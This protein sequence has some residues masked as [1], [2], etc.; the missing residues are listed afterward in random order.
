M[1]RKPRNCFETL[2][3]HWS[4]ASSKS[5]CVVC[6]RNFCSFCSLFCCIQCKSFWK[7]SFF[8]MC[9]DTSET[10]LQSVRAMPDAKHR[11][12]FLQR[13][14]NAQTCVARTLFP[15]KF[16]WTKVSCGKWVLSRK[17]EGESGIP[18][19]AHRPSL[20]F[21]SGMLVGKTVT[22]KHTVASTPLENSFV[23]GSWKTTLRSYKQHVETQWKVFH[24]WLEPVLNHHHHS[25]Q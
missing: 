14:Q 13:H 11:I 1:S 19:I 16:F 23:A 18:G 15:G 9:S 2:R 20:S 24:F 21:S 25:K 6:L 17:Q 8:V 3:M 7:L 22:M 5:L 10:C 12:R 4:H